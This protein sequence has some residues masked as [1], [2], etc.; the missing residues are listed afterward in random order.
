MSTEA[1][2]QQPVQGSSLG[3]T[4]LSMYDGGLDSMIE[5]PTALGCKTF[6]ET[7]RAQRVAANLDALYSV[8]WSEQELKCMLASAIDRLSELALDGQSVYRGG[9]LE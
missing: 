6:A 5:A 8:P 9:P 7:P 2:L 3:A 4:W 1:W